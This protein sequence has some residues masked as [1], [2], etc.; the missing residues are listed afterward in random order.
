[1]PD[2][3]SPPSPPNGQPQSGGRADLATTEELFGRH[4]DD[5]AAQIRDHLARGEKAK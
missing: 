1:M 2:T 4:A 3:T 5:L